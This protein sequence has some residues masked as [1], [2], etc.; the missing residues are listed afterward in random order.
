[1]VVKGVFY[2]SH[3]TC[4]CFHHRKTTNSHFT[5]IISISITKPQI[6]HLSDWSNFFDSLRI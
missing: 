1:M 3:V 5:T 4:S 6:D 2:N